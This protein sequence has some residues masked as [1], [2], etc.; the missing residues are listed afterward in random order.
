LLLFGLVLLVP[1]YADEPPKTHPNPYVDLYLQGFLEAEAKLS[2]TIALQNLA[3]VKLEMVKKL[4]VNG[5]VSKEE[6]LERAAGLEVA[7]ANVAEAR[8]YILETKALYQLVLFRTEA[9]QD[10]PICLR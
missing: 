2:Q 8:A 9:G 3:S 5:F 6:Y 4:V 10:M 1:I 7:I